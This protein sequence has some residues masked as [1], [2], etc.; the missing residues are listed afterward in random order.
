M[1]TARLTR[2]IVLLLAYGFQRPV[3]ESRATAARPRADLRRAVPFVPLK[4][5]VLR[6]VYLAAALSAALL[7][8]LVLSF[9]RL[10]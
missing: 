7:V 4:R 5:R 2:P 8:L 1:P 10:L 6:K 9:A 3:L